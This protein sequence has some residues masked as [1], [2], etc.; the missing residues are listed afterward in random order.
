MLEGLNPDEMTEAQLLGL[1]DE[2]VANPDL[3]REKPTGSMAGG[4]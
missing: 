3:F 4:K 2:A 1:Y